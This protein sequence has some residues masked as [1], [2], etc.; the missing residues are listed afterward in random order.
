MAGGPFLSF[1][2]PLTLTSPTVD[3]TPLMDAQGHLPQG[4]VG[5]TGPILTMVV[6]G[7]EVL[8]PGDPLLLPPFTGLVGVQASTSFQRTLGA[9]VR[10]WGRAP[11]WMAHCPVM[12]RQLTATSWTL[13]PLKSFSSSQGPL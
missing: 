13:A 7:G 3:Q 1:I 6:L 4:I 8:G 2:T 5:K 12:A 11:H 10:E 9:I